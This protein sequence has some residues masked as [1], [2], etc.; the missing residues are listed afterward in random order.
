MSFMI[1]WGSGTPSDSA[2][3]LTVDPE[4]IRI[5]STAVATDGSCGVGSC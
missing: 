5:V 4:L 3:C 1:T 2:A